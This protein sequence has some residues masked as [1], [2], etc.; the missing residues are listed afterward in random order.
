MNNYPKNIGKWLLLFFPI[1]WIC[2]GLGAYFFSNILDKEKL[3]QSGT[4]GDMFGAVNALFSGLAMAGVI[5]TITQQNQTIELHKE[6]LKQ[7]EKQEMRQQ[8]E[9]EETKLLSAKTALL[10]AYSKRIDWHHTQA[11]KSTI[12]ND[13]YNETMNKIDFLKKHTQLIQE[14]EV[15]VSKIDSK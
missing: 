6:E 9:L 1:I 3:A 11:E 14:L 8:K 7:T 12:E 5:Y 15:L 13:K 4:F 2:L 10:E